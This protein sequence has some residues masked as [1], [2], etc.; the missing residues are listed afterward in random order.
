MI[1]IAYNVRNLRVR[2]TTSL[3][4]ALGLALVV[5]IF[6]S[7]MMLSNG[8][9]KTTGRAGAD[10]QA[11]VLRKGATGEMESGVDEPN[12]GLI[13][14]TPGVA[15]YPNGR[16]EAVGELIVVMLLDKN[17]TTGFSNVQM[18]G[19]T[20]DVLQFR[21][22]V[23]VIAGRA[24]MPGTDEVMVGKGIRGRFKGLELD[25]SFEMKRN[26]PAHVVGIFDDGGSAF[27]SEIWADVGTVRATFGRQGIVSS[28]RVRLESPSKFDAFK[29]SIES[30]RQ[31]NV[32]ALQ[33][34]EYYERTSQGTTMFLTV[35][36]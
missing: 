29:A 34:K 11:I 3:A 21:P 17:G 1:P 20:D 14:A 4:T 7:A 9:K 23:H 2:K 28:V 10:D 36:G 18:R 32:Q 16:P 25:Q 5:F 13:A 26:R 30:N 33:D 27:E 6:A 19:V 24:P 8:I 22:G 31:L 12:I 35:L 15:K